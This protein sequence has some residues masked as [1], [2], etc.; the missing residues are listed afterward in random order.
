MKP[1]RRKKKSRKGK[2]SWN[3]LPTLLFAAVLLAAIAVFAAAGKSRARREAEA[4]KAPP[5]PP[6]IVTTAQRAAWTRL[7]DLERV[8]L[9]TE[10]PLEVW[11]EYPVFLET[12]AGFRRINAFFAKM[13]DAFFSQDNETLVQAIRA[14]TEFTWTNTAAV[15][16]NGVLVTVTL[17]RDGEEEVYTFRADTGERADPS[18]ASEEDSLPWVPEL[19]Y[20]TTAEENRGV[21][22]TTLDAQGLNFSSFFEVPLLEGDGPGIQAV[23]EFFQTLAGDFFSPEN[24]TLAQAWEYAA[25][26]SPENELWYYQRPLTV[27]YRTGKLLSVSI[28]YE[29]FLG[30]VTDYGSDSYTFRLDTG[31]RLTLARLVTERERELKQMIRAAAEEQ[32]AGTGSLDLERLE[33]YD[34]DDF[35][36]FV[37]NGEVFLAFDKYELADGAYGGFTLKLPATIR[38]EFL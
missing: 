30:G 24:T 35:E 16:F 10:L 22:R 31:E 21:R 38:E 2:S 36:F 37:E 18:E 25:Y 4:A 15:D 1:V 7:T 6:E 13:R 12:G 34:L 26:P 32:D 23:N 20:R 14:G 19:Q 17:E 8:T 27:R 3:A 28:G 33:G 5:P 11:L 29:W 9:K